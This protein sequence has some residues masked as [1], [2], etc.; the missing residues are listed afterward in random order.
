M[1]N[2]ESVGP[3]YDEAA[4]PKEQDEMTSNIHKTKDLHTSDT[5]QLPVSV[6]GFSLDVHRFVLAIATTEPYSTHSDLLEFTRVLE[7][8]HYVVAECR[9]Y[10][11]SFAAQ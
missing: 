1:R 2:S 11:S 5:S 10:L 7:T 4:R 6:R 9:R 8:V 3:T